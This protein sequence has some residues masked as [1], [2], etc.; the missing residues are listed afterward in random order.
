MNNTKKKESDSVVARVTSGVKITKTQNPRYR[1]SRAEHFAETSKDTEKKYQ[2]AKT[3]D[4]RNIHLST[5]AHAAARAAVHARFVK[6]KMP[7][8]ELADQATLHAQIA[9]DAHARAQATINLAQNEKEQKRIDD[10]KQRLGEIK[11]SHG[12]TKKYAAEVSNSVE[13]IKKMLEES[14]QK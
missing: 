3:D 10:E 14:G 12:E 13:I 1:A 9:Q 8:S 6:K 4:E 11:Q 5:L 7:G 2:A